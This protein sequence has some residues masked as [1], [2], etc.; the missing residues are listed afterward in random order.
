MSTWRNS[1]SSRMRT[2]NKLKPHKTR[3]RAIPSPPL[4]LVECGSPLKN[5]LVL[6]LLL[7]VQ[8]GMGQWIIVGHYMLREAKDRIMSAWCLVTNQIASSMLLCGERR[9]AI[10]RPPIFGQELKEF[11]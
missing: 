2:D 4:S 9:T 6:V 8:R 1:A 5:K 11:S 7:K 10:F 3:V